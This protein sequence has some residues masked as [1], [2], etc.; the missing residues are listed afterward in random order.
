MK[1]ILASIF[2]GIGLC[3]VA[4]TTLTI[5][6]GSPVFANYLS[7]GASLTNPTVMGQAIITNAYFTNTAAIL[8]DGAGNVAV[9]TNN[10]GGSGGGGGGGN[11]VSNA[12][13]FLSIIV[14]NAGNTSPTN[15]FILNNDYFAGYDGPVVVFRPVATNHPYMAMDI[16][17]K[18]PGVFDSHFS[19]LATDQRN[20]V[21]DYE[22]L[23][24]QDNS[25]G[26]H[27]YSDAHGSYSPQTL[28]LQDHGGTMTFGANNNW[29]WIANN[30][31][32]NQV[33]VSDVL[34]AG[35]VSSSFGNIVNLATNMWWY[36]GS[37]GAMSAVEI[38][39]N[40]A[41]AYSQLNLMRSGGGVKMGGTLVV[42]SNI[43]TTSGSVQ[44]TGFVSSNGVGASVVVPIWTNSGFT[45]GFNLCFT[46]GLLVSTNNF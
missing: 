4:Q 43:T 3:A 12:T 21:T 28:Y 2:T 6:L 14:T 23:E 29:N 11:V 46:N 17:P 45:H 18:G 16:S 10:F 37:A 32:N 1:K 8:P 41:A 25:A 5:Q 20:D 9:G 7:P 36:E 33:P 15:A 42:N 13:A 35:N 26:V 40:T 30:G 39:N 38:A 31:A 19:V 34:Y 24:M 22:D 44:A 27:V